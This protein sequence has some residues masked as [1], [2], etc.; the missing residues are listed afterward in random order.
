RPSIAVLGFKNLSN[1]SDAGWLSTAL[2]EMFTTELAADGQ[3]RTVR[4]ENVSRLKMELAVK[5]DQGFSKESFSQFH[6]RLG[7]DFL[8]DG[9]YLILNQNGQ[10]RVDLRVSNTQQDVVLAISEIGPEADLFTIVSN[11]GSRLRA[12]LG[13]NQTAPNEVDGA[14]AAFPQNPDA[15]RLD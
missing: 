3:L 14:R 6:K 9:S 5:D 1:R 15:V 13:L 11:A 4:L 12:Q 2:S 10:L 7:A 8:V